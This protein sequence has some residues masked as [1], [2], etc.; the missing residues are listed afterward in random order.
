MSKL[1]EL[2]P[3]FESRVVET[4]AAKL[5]ARIGGKGAPL[6]LLHGHPQTGAM[7]HRIAPELAKHYTLV[8]ADLIGYGASGTPESVP[9]HSPYTKRAMAAAMVELMEKLGHK[10]FALV[11]HDRGGRVGY[12]LAFDHPGRITRLSVLDIVPT[13][14][15]WAGMNAARAMAAYHWAFLAQRA[16]FPETLIGNSVD[17][18]FNWIFTGMRWGT[19]ASVFDPRA[20]EHYR[21]NFSDAAH[22]HGFCEDYRAGQSTDVEIDGVDLKAGKKIAC[23]VQVLWGARG[24]PARSGGEGMLDIWRRWAAN[25]EGQAVDCGHF[26][27]EENPDATLAALLPFLA[28][29]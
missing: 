27:P 17:F 8:I 2:F 16:P 10:R 7:Y 9:D 22:I 13:Y 25:V 1:P 29:D 28:K 14:E 4:K 11:G 18:Y 3:G 6:L 24:L 26:L 20:V 19:D 15:M 23:P 5:F 21:Q 12:R